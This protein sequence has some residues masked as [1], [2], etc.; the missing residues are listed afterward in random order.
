MKVVR[1]SDSP[2]T[3]VEGRPIFVGEVHS[4]ALVDAA[5]SA[6]VTVTLVRF[7]DGARNVP[8]THTADQLLYITE[9]AGIVASHETEHQ[10]L[11]GDIVHV[12]AGE[13]HWHGAISGGHMAH[14]SI[15]P[16]CETNIVEG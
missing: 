13:W 16:P 8:H 9:G 12:P 7:T 15:L 1:V 5:T 14:L 6:A 10:V 3:R 4:R 11:A 2:E